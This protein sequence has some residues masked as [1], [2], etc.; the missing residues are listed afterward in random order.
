MRLDKQY[1]INKA[2]LAAGI[3]L[4]KEIRVKSSDI[5]TALTNAFGEAPVLQCGENNDFND[6]LE[7]IWLCLN[8]DMEIQ[9]CPPSTAYSTCDDYVFFER[10]AKIPPKC[11]QDLV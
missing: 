11:V 4:Q 2:L 7:E 10:G 1:D 5:E 8:E 6:I 9:E 3:D